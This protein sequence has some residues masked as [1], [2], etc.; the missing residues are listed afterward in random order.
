MFHISLIKVYFLGIT[1]AKVDRFG[2]IGRKA[3][4]FG[5]NMGN[6]DMFS[7]T[8]AKGNMF[9]IIGR[10]GEK[11]GIT[12]AKMSRMGISGRKVVIEFCM[13]ISK[14]KTMGIWWEKTK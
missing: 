11:F 13:T 5:I 6:V 1:K 2:I 8:R 14:W 12:M 10:K 3:K 4:N 7:I 9:G